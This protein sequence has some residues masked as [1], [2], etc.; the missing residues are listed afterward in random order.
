MSGFINA[1]RLQ[2]FFNWHVFTLLAR[3]SVKGTIWERDGTMQPRLRVLHVLIYF[4]PNFT[5]EG[6]FLERL[7]SVFDRLAPDVWHDILV[8]GTPQPETP[9][10]SGSAVRRVFYLTRRAW[11]PFVRQ[12]LLWWW[13][14]RNVHRYRVIHYHTHADRY[15][16]AA[17]IA[18]LFG[19]RLL[20]SATLDD[21]VPFVLQ[22][23]RPQ[24]RSLARKGLL[25][26]DAF[27]SIS[28]KLHDQTKAVAPDKVH[29]IPVGITIPPSGDRSARSADRRRFGIAEDDIV[30]I[31]VGGVCAR[32]DPFFLIKQLPRT[33]DIYPKIKIL[34]VGPFV[35]PEYYAQITAYLRKNELNDHVIFTGEVRD[36]YPMFRISDIMTFASR[37]EGFGTA[38]IEAMAHKVPVVVRHLP[39][40]NDSFVINGKTGFLFTDEQEYL[41][42]LNILLN[43]AELR[44]KIGDDARQFVINNFDISDISKKYLNL[45]D[46][47]NVLPKT[48]I[49]QPVL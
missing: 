8:V 32:K 38:V 28:P 24:F 29:L 36:P 15:F 7:V 48:K 35:E 26:F 3:G 12:M 45:Y 2:D 33:L 5:G 13:M 47:L 25:A 27:L 18:K 22:S 11:S 16:V 40:V 46:R 42:F 43:D 6:I 4:R 23:Y 17:L 41:G 9:S 44:K 14:L 21:S 10:C 37:L 39:G 34:V 19:K 30:L 1:L 49:V 20:L 31:F